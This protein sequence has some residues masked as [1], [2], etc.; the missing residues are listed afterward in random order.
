MS[1]II[2]ERKRMSEQQAEYKKAAQSLGS[3]KLESHI[4]LGIMKAVNDEKITLKAWLVV[5]DIID[6]YNPEA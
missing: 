5:K 3:T 1:L 2:H 4:R 6:S